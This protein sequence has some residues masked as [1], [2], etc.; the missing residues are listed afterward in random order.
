VLGYT[1]TALV[2]K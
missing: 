2:D 1:A